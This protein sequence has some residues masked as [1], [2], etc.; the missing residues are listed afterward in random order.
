MKQ[1]NN[2]IEITEFLIQEIQNPTLLNLLYCIYRPSSYQGICE[3]LIA[4]SFADLIT[5]EQR[6]NF[7][8]SYISPKLQNKKLWLFPSSLIHPRVE[9]LQNLLE[10]LKKT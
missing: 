6:I 1:L 4:M 10:D 2:D 5:F 7:F 8:E 3:A 9:F